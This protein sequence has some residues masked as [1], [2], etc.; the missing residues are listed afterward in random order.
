MGQCKDRTSDG[1][2]LTNR[3]F[4][5]EGAETLSNTLQNVIDTL[6]E[7]L[8]HLEESSEVLECSG[9]LIEIHE[10][11]GQDATIEQVQEIL[12]GDLT[13]E[14]AKEVLQCSTNFAELIADPIKYRLHCLDG[15]ADLRR[16]L[17]RN[18]CCATEILF[19]CLTEILTRLVDTI[20]KG[21]ET[22]ADVIKNL[23]DIDEALASAT[24]SS[25]E[26]LLDSLEE[27]SKCFTNGCQ[28]KLDALKRGLPSIRYSFDDLTG[29][30][31]SLEIINQVTKFDHQSGNHSEYLTDDSEE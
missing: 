9:D 10:H 20:A 26:A 2:D 4:R 24:A 12:Q 28:D 22:V 18:L 23:R 3:E 14:I 30:D 1:S 19:K 31:E 27:P 15:I 17:L 11:H 5:F 7:I 13:R 6:L 29:V 8:T 21:F 16:Y 25:K